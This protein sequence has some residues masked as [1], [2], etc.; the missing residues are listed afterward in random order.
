[1]QIGVHHRRG[2]IFGQCCAFLDTAGHDHA[3][4]G[5]NHR[6]LGLGQHACRRIQRL[7]TA[8]AALQ[9]VRLRTLV[10]A[11]AVEIVTRNIDLHR[12][13][14]SHR[15]VKGATGQ[16]GNTQRRIDVHLPFG[17]FRENRHLLG[18]LETAQTH[19]QAA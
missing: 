15:D 1:M 4:A 12:T 7:R 3:A 9:L 19:R 16:L 18:F 6:E 5:Q 11:F 8:G 17:D 2:Q 14:F 10:F 13:T